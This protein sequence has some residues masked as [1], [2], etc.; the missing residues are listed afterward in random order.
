MPK[1]AWYF[2]IL[3][4]PPIFNF[5]LV[6][7]LSVEV[8]IIWKISQMKRL[9]KYSSE[10]LLLKANSQ[11]HLFALF[12]RVCRTR[13]E[14][15][16]RV[17]SIIHFTTNFCSLTWLIS[18]TYCSTLNS[19]KLIGFTSAHWRWVA[20]KEKRLMLPC[21]VQ[22]AKLFSHPLMVTFYFKTPTPFPL[23][24]SAGLSNVVDNLGTDFGWWFSLKHHLILMQ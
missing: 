19:A 11:I 15:V 8:S 6:Q 13:Q 4:F 24:T 18:W 22:E 14:L 5:L 10:I 23:L 12:P 7:F 9:I 1:Y 3:L 16:K 2:R 20:R 17:D 21:Y